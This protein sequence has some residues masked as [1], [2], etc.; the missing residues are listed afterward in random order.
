[1][2][3][4]FY[5]TGIIVI[6]IVVYLLARKMYFKWKT[7]LLLPVAVST[8]MIIVLLEL[9]QLSYETYML[10]GKWIMELLGPAVV[11]LAYPLYH[12]RETLK[13]L[14][15]PIIAGA[16]VGS[17][18]GIVSGVGLAILA[19]IDH[20]LISSL[21]P[22]SVTTPVAMDLAIA[23][24]G[25][26]SLAA[27]FVMIAGIGGVMMSTTVFK[28]GKVNHPVGRGLG[29]GSASHAIGTS[30]ALENN[31]FEG[32]IST[33]AMILCAFFVSIMLPPII[34]WWL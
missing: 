25:I 5:T 15:L 8:V 26:Q 7:P 22:K 18:I 3:N 28:Y 1:M 30:R 11:A 24:G 14:F 12:H 21:G 31:E 20:A 29:I 9:F 32:S 34:A 6:T 33:I 2:S 19:N 13:Q 17:F 10:G 4:F 16:F 27:V 23:T